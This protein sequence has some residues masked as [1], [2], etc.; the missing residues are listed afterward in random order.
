MTTP[1][2]EQVGQLMVRAG[3]RSTIRI[4]RIVAPGVIYCAETEFDTV[5]YGR[6]YKRADG[7][8]YD[9]ADATPN[10]GRWTFRWAPSG[11]GKKR[12]G[13]LR[14]AT[15]EEE[16]IEQARLKRNRDEMAS[17]AQALQKWLPDL[18]DEQA[19]RFAKRPRIMHES[20]KLVGITSG[21]DFLEWLLTPTH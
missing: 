8:T 12:V 20:E 9:E 13:K 18:S 16:E 2:R 6:T 5:E 10:K 11:P 3:T 1:L 21:N 17:R 19:Q 14:F 15:P 4:A 7:E